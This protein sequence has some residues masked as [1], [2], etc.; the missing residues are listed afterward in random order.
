MSLLFKVVKGTLLG[1]LVLLLTLFALLVFLLGTTKGAQWASKIASDN[2]QGIITLNL[3]IEDGNVWQG[4]QVKNVLVEV[5]EVIEVKAQSLNTTWDLTQVLLN[6]LLEVSA[7]HADDLTVTLKVP[8]SGEETQEEEEVVEDPN[9][10]PFR[11]NFPVDIVIKDFKVK[12][13]AYLSKI[14]DVSIQDFKAF[15][16]AVGD[17]ASLRGGKA[18][19]PVVHLKNTQTKEEI[20]AQEAQDQQEKK[21]IIQSAQAKEGDLKEVIGAGVYSE[22]VLRHSDEADLNTFG[23][24]N[25]LISQMPNIALPLD[26]EVLG[27]EIEGGRYYMDGFDTH[28]V[29]ANL[30]ATWEDSILKVIRLDAS[31]FMGEVSAFG[32]LDFKEHFK[33]DFNLQGEGAIT[34]YNRT[35]FEGLLHGLKGQVKV[36]GDLVDL[37][38]TAKFINPE[39]T[40]LE[41]RVNCLSSLI[42]LSIKLDSNYLR[43][44]LFTKEA[45]AEA[46][47]LHFSSVGSLIKG[48]DT[49]LQG[50]FT[51]YGFNDYVADFKGKVSLQK[52]EIDNLS[53]QGQYQGANVSLNAQG[54]VDYFRRMGFSGSIDAKASEAKFIA[55]QLQGPLELNAQ[56][57]K[58]A[59]VPNSPSRF[60]DF[61]LYAK[62]PHFSS[63]L[64]LNHIPATLNLKEVSGNLNQG[65][66][67]EDLLFVQGENNLNLK[68]NISNLSDLKATLDFKALDK[69]VPGLQGEVS[70]ELQAQG[71][72]DNLDVALSTRISRLRQ[73][74]MRIR[75]LLFDA[76]G[77]SLEKNFEVTAIANRINLS[78]S[79]DRLDQCVLDFSGDLAFHQLSLNCN[80]KA[81]GFLAITGSLTEDFKLWSGKF[82]ELFLQSE[83]SGSV[84]LVDPIEI[85][86]NSEESHLEV[87]P[88]TLRGENGSLNVD[89]TSFAPGN[90]IS[91]VNFKDYDLKSLNDLMPDE[92]RLAGPVSLTSQILIKDGIPD[93]KID[94]DSADTRIF[95]Y[96]VPLLFDKLAL[97]VNGGGKSLEIE[98][99]LHLRDDRGSVALDL[100]VLDPLKTRRLDGTFKLQ[101]LNL[102]LFSGVGSQFNDLQGK[103]NIDGRF[104]GD[105]SK[106]L[107]IGEISAQGQAEPRLDVG[108]IDEFDFKINALGQ[109]GELQGLIKLNGSPVNLTGTLDWSEGAK[110]NLEVKATRLPAFLVGFGQA[111]AN[112]DTKVTFD[113]AFYVTGK[114]EIPEARIRVNNI[115]DSGSQPSGDEI[116]VPEG[117]TQELV[118]NIKPPVPS[119]IDLNLSLGDNVQLSAMGL[120]SRLEGG[121]QV[122]KALSD[123]NIKGLGEIQVVDGKADLFG[124]RFIVNHA[125]TIF[126]GNI[127]DPRLD[128]EVIADP[129]DMEDEVTAGVKVTGTA[130]DPRIELFSEP[131]MSDNEVLSYI[132][133]G[134]GLE[135]NSSLNQE[136]TNSSQMLLGLGLGSTTGLVNALVGAFGVQNVQVGASGSGDETQVSV[137]GYLTRKI[138]ISYG[139]GVFNAVG[140]FKVRYE[141]MRRLYAEFVSSVDQAADLIYSFEF[142]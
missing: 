90:L 111:L 24:G 142:D 62:I 86:F 104:A 55:S 112:I 134:H 29:F 136:N 140:E 53:L 105:V 50:S 36:E 135:K 37:K 106:P 39:E 18:L 121:L 64:Y 93:L 109:T 70:G 88:F 38:A 72:L 123:K 100:Q 84:S 98:S 10:P 15:L 120:T 51:G 17:K 12:N 46:R 103:A 43:W 49:S 56:D 2:L 4:L 54:I 9:A 35:H 19:K 28:E 6:N 68:G 66:V 132:L 20:A 16:E 80:G 83:L 14:V 91:G 1:F 48:L 101:D 40:N 107:F 61:N 99:A 41:V 11:L 58:L 32:A 45:S 137:Q 23:D 34:D 87:K 129:E 74:E 138:R 124:H 94:L 42:P 78:P 119:V 114:V 79:L 118:A 75:E 7:L 125:R 33:L 139:Y 89:A 69:L 96:G 13:F 59:F 113:E 31:H 116:L 130:S 92:V 44:P 8:D 27:L 5:P 67:I 117:G 52:T 110:G 65:F 128:V 97:N 57:L 63:A 81:K 71:N 60:G 126:N 122:Q 133:Y 3:E 131:S 102:A 82:E 76:R 85:A 21:E 108:Q 22:Q 115:I 26:V 25:G 95:A 30:S 127:A 77:N 47:N 73:G 141:F